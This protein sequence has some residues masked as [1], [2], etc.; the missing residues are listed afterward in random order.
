MGERANN[1]NTS[2]TRENEIKRK[3]ERNGEIKKERMTHKY[4]DKETDIRDLDKE[5]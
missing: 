3:E 4:G 1:R 5:R 2:K